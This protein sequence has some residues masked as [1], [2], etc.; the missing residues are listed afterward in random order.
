MAFVNVN[1][2]HGVGTILVSLQAHVALTHLLN[3]ATLSI[4]GTRS[5]LDVA[6]AEIET[7][8]GMLRAKFAEGDLRPEGD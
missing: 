4:S 7:A 8:I 3:R 6:I 2:Q 5:E 1:H